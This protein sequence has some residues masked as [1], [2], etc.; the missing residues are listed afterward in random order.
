MYKLSNKKAYDFNFN[1]GYNF[2]IKNIKLNPKTYATL[3]KIVNF[4]CFH[5]KRSFFFQQ[6]GNFTT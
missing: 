6:T 4:H 3:I 1:W 2:I 5:I